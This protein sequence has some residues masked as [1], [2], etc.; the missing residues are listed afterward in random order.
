M[1]AVS[2]IVVVG[3]L[4]TDMVFH[5]SRLPVPGETLCACDAN[6]SSGGKGANQAIAAARLGARVTILGKVGMDFQ[7]DELMRNLND[8]GVNTEHL[9]RDTGT[10]SG[11]AVVIVDDDGKNM[12]VVWPAANGGFS[13]ADLLA[14]EPAIFDS[15][16][17]ITQFE[18]PLDTVKQALRVAK[19]QDVLTVCNPAPAV[20]I[21]REFLEMVDILI[22][23]ETEASTLTGMNVAT[24]ADA[25]QAGLRLRDMGVQ[26]LVVTMGNQGAV[27]IGPEGQWHCPIFQVNSI[28]T[29]G[30]GDAFVAAFTVA[31]VKNPDPVNSLRY[32]SAVGAFATTFA[33]AQ[34]P[35]D[36]RKGVKKLLEREDITPTLVD[37]K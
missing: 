4:N 12:I 24:V 25:L 34:L 18:I 29:T 33:G 9:I 20:A 14:Q 11:M 10:S 22:P 19:E 37:R 30:A 5:V 6:F 13:G 27:Y 31:W 1:N 36:C 21:G 28:D 16:A 17:V 15:D 8:A 26:R 23:N 35:S 32:A 3:S 2:K 7:T